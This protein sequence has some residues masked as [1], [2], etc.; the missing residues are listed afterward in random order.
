MLIWMVLGVVLAGCFAAGT[1]PGDHWLDLVWGIRR[2]RF[3]VTLWELTL[4][5]IG[6]VANVVCQT[7]AGAFRIL[8]F[9]L[10]CLMIVS[11]RA[12]ERIGSSLPTYPKDERKEV[13]K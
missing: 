4:N 8:T 11:D 10:G 9:V 12:G 7:L 1:I 6:V 13:E 2:I 3:S 5:V